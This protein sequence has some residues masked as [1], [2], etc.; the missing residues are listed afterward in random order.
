[1]N[2]ELGQKAYNWNTLDTTLMHYRLFC[3][4]LF[5]DIHTKHAPLIQ[6]VPL[7]PWE[8]LH[9]FRKSTEEKYFIR[10]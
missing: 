7:Q 1:M 6:V 8:R 3:S 2:T 4:V 9:H 10:Q 5:V